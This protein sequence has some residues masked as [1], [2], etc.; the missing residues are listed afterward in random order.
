MC[1]SVTRSRRSKTTDEQSGIHR[2]LLMK[3]LRTWNVNTVWRSWSQPEDGRL[4]ESDVDCDFKE[5]SLVTE[6]EEPE[7]Q[8][9]EMQTCL[10]PCICAVGDDNPC[11]FS[12]QKR[13]LFPYPWIC[14][15][16]ITC[17]SG[18]MQCMGNDGLGMGLKILACLH[19]SLTVLP[20]PPSQPWLVCW[21]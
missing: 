18:C 6:E 9:R 16:F 8:V 17:I 11:H 3:R 13:N 1:F 14:V 2:S 20:T 7:D 5:K 19:C 15:G 10:S 12:I 21:G 4:W